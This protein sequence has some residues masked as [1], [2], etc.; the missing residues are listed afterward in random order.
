MHFQRFIGIDYSGADSPLTARPNMAVFEASRGSRSAA[1][2][3]GYWSRKS[4]FDYLVSLLDGEPA[5]IG[6]DHGFSWPVEALDHLGLT[7]WPE[8]LQHVET[9]YGCLRE[10]R[11]K[12]QVDVR[13]EPFTKF[14]THLRLTEKRTPDAKPVF[15][16]QPHGVSWSTLAG[17]PWL[18]ILRRDYGNRI[19]FWPFDGWTPEAGKHCIV[20]IYPRLFQ[21]LYAE[22]C[23]HMT[24]DE[25]DAFCAAEWLR[26]MRQHGLLDRYFDPPRTKQE[27]E[28]CRR[29]G[30]I[31]GVM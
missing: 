16:F 31:L 23:G 21:R 12:G 18:S 9:Q 8:L 1:P 24:K 5:L 22:Q 3:P 14:D 4:V 15:A 13:G 6:V 10:Q 28:V 30:W 2:V 20:E 29:E 19:H 7:S 11:I 26:D 27:D 17:L 25:R